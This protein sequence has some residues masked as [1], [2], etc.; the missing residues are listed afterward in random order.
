MFTSKRCYVD[1]TKGYYSDP[2]S[3]ICLIRAQFENAGCP[4]FAPF[5]GR[6]DL[7]KDNY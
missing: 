7:N 3:F 1:E 5:F 2:E 4:K 6:D